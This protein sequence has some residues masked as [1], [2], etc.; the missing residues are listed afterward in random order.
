MPVRLSSLDRRRQ[1][2]RTASGIFAR[3][4]YRGT[5][6]R[7][8]AERNFTYNDHLQLATLRY[9]KNS[10]EILN[11]AYDYTSGVSG[12]NGQIQKMHYYTTPGTEDL[13]KS[14][15]FT[16]DQQVRLSAAQTGV[17]NSTSGAKTWSLQW[18]YDRFGNRLTQSMPA[19]DPTL[20]VSTPNFAIDPATN[21]IVGYCYAVVSG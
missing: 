4:G 14:E 19:G 10:T 21:R 5:T 16:Y 12:N 6:T 17:V 7:E 3:R 2:L 20:S 8:I 15:N 18:T 13:T 9:F 1:T 11:L